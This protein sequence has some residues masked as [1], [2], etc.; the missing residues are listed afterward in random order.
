MVGGDV[1]PPNPLPP[2]PYIPHPPAQ[3]LDPHS[4]CLVTASIGGGGGDVSPS[5]ISRWTLFTKANRDLSGFFP[6]RH[7][8]GWICSRPCSC[9]VNVCKNVN[10]LSFFFFFL[11]FMERPKCFA[12]SLMYSFGSYFLM[13]CK[14]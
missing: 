10:Y 4:C 14:K 11:F 5:S 12:K 1:P 7:S 2:A 13:K 8:P 9:F 3:L 6:R